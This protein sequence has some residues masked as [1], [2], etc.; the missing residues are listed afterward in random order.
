MLRYATLCY[1]MLCYAYAML[2]YVTCYVLLCYAMRPIVGDGTVYLTSE[3]S[4]EVQLLVD[5]RIGW[6]RWTR[7]RTYSYI[8]DTYHPLSSFDSHSDIKTF[9]LLHIKTDYVHLISFIHRHHVEFWC[10]CGT[11][12]CVSS[13]HSCPFWRRLCGSWYLTKGRASWWLTGLSWRIRNHFLL[14]PMQVS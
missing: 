9:H 2:C 6:I 12:V 7:T 1:A 3:C 11:H 5:W 13:T 14:T 8:P 10:M 4:F